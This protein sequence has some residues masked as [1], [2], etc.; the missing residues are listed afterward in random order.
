MG[1]GVVQVSAANGF[2]VVAFD[3]DQKFVD[4]GIDRVSKSVTKLTKKLVE[5]GKLGEED[6]NKQISDTMG[7]ITATT[8]FSLL[9]DCDLVVEAATENMDLKRDIF[10]RL[11][12]IAKPTQILASNTSSLRITPMGEFFGRPAQTVGLHF[13]NPV[14]LMKLVEVV[15]TENT[16]DTVIDSMVDFSKAV[17]KVPIVCKD[18]PGFVVNR[19][20][21]PYLATAMQLVDNGVASAE[22]IDIGMQLGAGHPMG[23]IHLADYIGLDTMLHILRGWVQDYPGDPAFFV[24][25]GLEAKVAEGKLGRKTGEGYYKWDGDKKL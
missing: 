19:L 7:R 1:H 2:E 9:G 20:L 10:G 17:G 6:G 4:G 24:P 8:D 3:I 13:F 11:G 16:S 22:D 14:Q 25:K 18:T 12:S 21:V 5:K 23:P 15:K